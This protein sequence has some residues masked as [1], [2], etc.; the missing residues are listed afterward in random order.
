MN[1]DVANAEPSAVVMA[2]IVHLHRQI[3]RADDVQGILGTPLLVPDVA[4]HARLTPL[5]TEIVRLLP[6]LT[7]VCRQPHDRLGVEHVLLR[8]PQARRVPVEGLV[9][10]A[11]RSEDWAGVEFDRVIPERLLAIRYTDDYDFYENQV[12][13]QLVDR[14]R[15]YLGGRIS[16]LRLLMRHLGD[17]SRYGAALE[18]KQSYWKRR[19]LSNLLAEA[20]EAAKDQVGPVATTLKTLED[21]NGKVNL[22]R[23]SPVYDRANR[24]APIA[25]R[26][27]RTNLLT[28][29]HKYHRTALLWEAWAL[30][31]ADQ[32][33]LLK[34]QHRD[35]EPAYN[36]YILALVLRAFGVLGFEA[37][38]GPPP[39]IGRRIELVD[40]HEFHIR[41]QITADERIEVRLGNETIAVIVPFSSDITA[42]PSAAHVQQAVDALLRKYGAGSVST[43]I[44]Y[45]GDRSE[46]A[47]L[48][49]NLQDQVHWTGR[50]STF[51]GTPQRLLGVV[52]VSPLEIESAER[53][54]RS[55]RWILHATRLQQ[56]FP[57]R[58]SAEPWLQ[59]KPR[60][61]L[62]PQG[63]GWILAKPLTPGESGELRD[64]I[65]AL[66]SVHTA[67]SRSARPEPAEEV[68]ARVDAAEQSL[69]LISNC[70]LCPGTGPVAFEA[71]SSTYHCRCECGAQWG[72]RICGSCKERF[73]VLWTSTV[74]ESGVTNLVDG[75]TIDAALGSE[76]LALLCPTVADRPRFKCPW[77][78]ICQGAPACDC[79]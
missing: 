2:S 33:A 43:V 35:F 71:R 45:P 49:Q 55:L 66:S 34:Q 65:R 62:R 48:P 23:S 58:I 50:F 27:P 57:P 68:I 53:M 21:L 16:D 29:N 10:L 60:S 38:N 67:R 54:A 41:L 7:A 22:L 30:R 11:S 77:C 61:W 39:E 73:P 37:V 69:R 24:R 8:A 32:A 74:I 46:R 3:A 20:V 78:G 72:T 4:D 31:D 36:T 70:P 13:A 75:D 18:G 12:A 59:L 1:G 25:Y 5:D 52:P 63:Q 6:A 76:A 56:L 17:L 42:G 64:E 51:R 47:S 9:R 28:G 15:R 44:A 14:L 26:L 79:S 40:G 19:R